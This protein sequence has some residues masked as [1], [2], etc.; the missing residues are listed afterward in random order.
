MAHVVGDPE[1]WTY[2]G[3]RKLHRK[4]SHEEGSRKMEDDILKGR[5]GHEL[6]KLP[7]FPLDTVLFPQAS[8][9]LHV[10]EDRYRELVR[11]CLDEERP[12]G[13]V[14]IRAGEE[15]GGFA[16]PYMVGTLARIKDVSRFDDG[17]M[18]IHII[19]ERRFRIRRL[20]EDA[21]PFLVGHVEPVL[22]HPIEDDDRAEV[23][24]MQARENVELLV[25]RFFERQHFSVQVMFPT[26]AVDLSFSIANLLSMENL[27]KQRLLET[28]DT[29]DR[30]EDLLPVLQDAL[31]ESESP[32]YFR[33]AS[34]DLAEWVNPN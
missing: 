24:V 9:R 25:K 19:G 6:E 31:Q 18:D 23:L 29:L 16:D 10:F 5:M 34:R 14:L 4:L 27:Q 11:V 7:L 3:E 28:T 30:F 1:L 26:D 2:G 22:E 8:L 32:N 21:A 13:V 33:I 17:R 15:V 20:D 12:F